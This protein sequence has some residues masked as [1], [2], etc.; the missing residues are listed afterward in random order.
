M[1]IVTIVPTS[2]YTDNPVSTVPPISS[3]TVNKKHMLGIS[4]YVDNKY[5][6]LSTNNDILIIVR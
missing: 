1:G 4:T 3:Y 5:P 2:T 6:G